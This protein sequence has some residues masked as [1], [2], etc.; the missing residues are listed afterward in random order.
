MNIGNPR[1]VEMWLDA[2]C[3]KFQGQGKPF[4][5]EEFDRLLGHC[6]AVSDVPCI[7]FWMELMDAYPDA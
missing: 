6:M 3:A 5:R 1:D 7:S 2:Y 4:G